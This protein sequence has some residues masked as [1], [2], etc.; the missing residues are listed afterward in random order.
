MVPGALWG[1]WDQAFCLLHNKCESRPT[2]TRHEGNNSGRVVRV[3]GRLWGV[4][5]PV[6]PDPRKRTGESRRSPWSRFAT[7][8]ARTVSKGTTHAGHRADGRA[9]VDWVPRAAMGPMG[10]SGPPHR[11]SVRIATLAQYRIAGHFSAHG[12]SDRPCIIPSTGGVVTKGA[13]KS[14]RPLEDVVLARNGAGHF[15][16]LPAVRAG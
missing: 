2:A 15:N 16:C 5:Y 4:R 10:V 13:N 11:P 7:A 12:M 3:T 14:W 6:S 8:S 9:K 1:C